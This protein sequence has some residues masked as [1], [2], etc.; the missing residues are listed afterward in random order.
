MEAEREE[1][2]TSW[3]EGFEVGTKSGSSV[4]FALPTCSA[5]NLA[6]RL[7]RP[8]PLQWV[9]PRE[10]EE[11]NKTDFPLSFMPCCQQFIREIIGLSLLSLSPLLLFPYK[12]L[13]AISKKSFSLPFVRVLFFFFFFLV[14]FQL[15]ASYV[16]ITKYYSQVKQAAVSV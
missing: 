5:R 13:D 10:S 11:R 6:L 1:N 8:T 4:S 15:D 7:F 12:Q 9:P 3:S 14:P 16:S 2:W